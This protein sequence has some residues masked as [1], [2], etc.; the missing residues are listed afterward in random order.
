MN[1][2][3]LLVGSVVVLST[4]VAGSAIG[5]TSATAA[6]PARSVATAGSSVIEAVTQEQFESQGFRSVHLIVSVTTDTHLVL[7]DPA[8]DVVGDRAADRR[9]PASFWITPDGSDTAGYTLRDTRGGT[10]SVEVDFRGMPLSVPVDQ[11]SGS[12]LEAVSRAVENGQYDHDFRYSVLPGAT[13]TVGANGVEHT[14]EAD[15]RGIATVPVHLQQGENVL[16]AKQTLGAKSSDVGKTNYL[17]GIDD[18][19]SGGGTPNPGGGSPNPG[20]GSPNP[21]GGDHG[22]EQSGDRAFS[23][24]RGNEQVRS[25][26]G[27]ITLTGSA[28]TGQVSVRKG[29]RTLASA[30]VVDGRWTVEVPVGFGFSLLQV[31][32]VK[33]PGGRVIETQ[34]L[35][36]RVS[37]H[38]DAF[39]VDVPAGQLTAVGGTVTI[40]GTATD[41][42]VAVRG[43]NG[44]VARTTVRDGG[45]SLDLP[46]HSGRQTVRFEHWT[47]GSEGFPQ[48]I[49]K[50]LD[51]VETGTAPGT[52]FAVDLGTGKFTAHDGVV[53]LSGTAP[54][55]EVALF[56]RGKE[57][58]RAGVV[59]GH[60]TV[61]APLEAGTHMVSFKSFGG[62]YVGDKNYVMVVN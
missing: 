28:T 61:D 52:P 39:A 50:L 20:G 55:K 62:E 35:S 40:S 27:V 54:G 33:A 49:E 21:G 43:A 4:C 14:V 11:S 42:V 25:M 48:E 53:M 1:F 2:R 47:D 60:W 8:G 23:V 13:V 57:I 24:D 26:T 56:E 44:S 37:F 31:D 29:D 41:G 51:V 5:V 30:P 46:V 6:E 7:V 38:D 18:G 19:Q 16:S 22:G 45:W 15:S 10:R 58:A 9:S 12:Q 34:S 32:L 59:D 17:F 36:T 3:P